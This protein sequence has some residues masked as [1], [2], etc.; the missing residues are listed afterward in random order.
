MKP[1]IYIYIYR[2]LS[3][4]LY[5]YIYVNIYINT[6]W[7]DCIYPYPNNWMEKILEPDIFFNS[8]VDSLGFSN[9]R[10]KII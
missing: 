10:K 8:S 4:S 7:I 3:L 6:A 5:I 2:S 1:I 9:H